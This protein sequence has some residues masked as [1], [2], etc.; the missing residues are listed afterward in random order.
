V[1]YWLPYVNIQDIEIEMTDEMKD[2]HIA[3]MKVEFTIGNQIDLQEIT[4]I[5]R[6]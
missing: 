4:F 2:R 1:N 3:H 5:V 6:G